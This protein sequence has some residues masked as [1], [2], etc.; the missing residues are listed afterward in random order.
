MLA[1]L[2]LPSGRLTRL[3]DSSLA[4]GTPYADVARGIAIFDAYEESNVEKR[5]VYGVRLDRP[6]ACRAPRPDRPGGRGAHAGGA[7]NRADCAPRQ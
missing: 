4:V 3:T 1:T 6:G 5:G 2:D 7:G